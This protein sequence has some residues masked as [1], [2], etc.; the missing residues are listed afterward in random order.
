MT[1]AQISQLLFPIGTIAIALGF[2]AHV[3]HAVMLANG[4]RSLS[5]RPQP[6]ARLGRGSD[7]VV[8]GRPDVGRRGGTGAC[9][10][11]DPAWSGRGRP[12]RRRVRHPGRV[13]APPGHRRRP[14]AVG[15]HVR[16]HGRVRD[17]DR[18]RLSGAPAAL[19]DPFDRLHPRRHRPRA[20]ALRIEPRL[21][22]QRARAG[23]AE[24][25][26]AD[27]PR[28]DGG[29]QLRDVRDELRGRRRLPHPGSRRTGS[30]GSRRTRSS[31]KSPI[32]R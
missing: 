30:D 3:G 13:A 27:D 28:R 20:P 14:R 4:R 31:T 16:V 8:R 32:D 29:H 5:I 19:P 10:L 22:D 17:V 26:A 25:A 7:G 11:P 12:D 9:R 1:L 21:G 2:A 18:R 6:P 15:Q 24:R 23:A